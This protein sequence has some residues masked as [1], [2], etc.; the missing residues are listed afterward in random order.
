MK[1][2][3]EIAFDH[4]HGVDAYEDS[5]EEVGHPEGQPIIETFPQLVELIENAIEVDRAQ[6]REA[7]AQP[8]AVPGFRPFQPATVDTLIDS[9]EVFDG[10]DLSV[11]IDAWNDYTAG[12]DFPCPETPS[13]S[14]QVSDGSCD[15]CG[16]KNRS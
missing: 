6:V 16:D 3:Q 13:G 14:H 4:A 10:D 8:H 9:Y 5:A 11:F 1:T 7:L 12:I 15:L 2:P